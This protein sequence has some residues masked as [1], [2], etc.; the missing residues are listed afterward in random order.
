MGGF[1]MADM[2][3]FTIRFG[4]VAASA[5]AC[6]APRSAPPPIQ[7]PTRAISASYDPS[8]DL[9]PLFHDVQLAGIFADSKTFVDAVPRRAPNTIVSAYDSARLRPAFDLRAFVASNF[10]MPAELG[11]G[12]RVD[13]TLDMAAHIRALWLVLTRSA[14]S[15]I[16]TSTLIPLPSAFVVPGGRFREVYYWDSYFTMLGLLASGR[17]DLVKSMLD[18]FAYLVRVVGHVPNGNR[19][20]Y[21]SRSQPPYFAAMVGLYARATDTTRALVY[22][23]ALEREHAFWMDG[24]ADLA[25]GTARP[26]RRAARGRSA[27]QSLLGRSHRPSARV[28]QAGLRARR[29]PHRCA[30]RLAISR[31]SRN[32]RK[33]MGFLQPLDARSLGSPNPRDDGARAGGSQQPPL[34]R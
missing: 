15:S 18:N 1:V 32:G 23:D 6:A 12:A 3:Q 2:R 17:A 19:T 22:L 27:A 14:D 21:L 9:G 25:P 33:R 24:A 30:A 34:S 28:V 4:I 11:A 7:A 5:S 8:R 16:G 10:S 29:D 31:N 26:A 20:Y 13:T